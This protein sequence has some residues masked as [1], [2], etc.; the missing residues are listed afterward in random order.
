MCPQGVQQPWA[1]DD[2]RPG[3]REEECQ[4]SVGASKGYSVSLGRLFFCSY[5]PL[6]KYSFTKYLFLISIFNNFKT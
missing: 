5:I 3:H 2:D 6:I 4:H 1:D